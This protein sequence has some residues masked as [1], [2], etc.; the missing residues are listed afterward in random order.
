MAFEISFTCP[1][2]SP[3]NPTFFGPKGNV[4]YDPQLRLVIRDVKT[5]IVLWEITKHLEPALLQGHR[6]KNFDRAMAALVLDLKNLT[7]PSQTGS[8]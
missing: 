3:K 8:R 6:N 5:H 4:H 1:A 2:E 7:R